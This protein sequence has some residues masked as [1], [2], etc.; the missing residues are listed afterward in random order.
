MVS[1]VSHRKEFVSDDDF[2]RGDFLVDFILSLG[3]MILYFLLEGGSCLSLMFDCSCVKQLCT[4]IRTLRNGCHALSIII[5]E[6][7]SS[8][9]M[10][11]SILYISK[12]CLWKIMVSLRPVR[13]RY[14]CS[15]CLHHRRL[16]PILSLFLV[17]LVKILSQILDR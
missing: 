6:A 12:N 3:L 1:E 16:V 8:S 10:C 2:I 13:H 17:D 9:K 11:S 4:L 15:T 7:S 14:A 5:S